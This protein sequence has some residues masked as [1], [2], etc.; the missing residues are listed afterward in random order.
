MQQ[1]IHSIRV[2][3][4]DDVVNSNKWLLTDKSNTCEWN[5]AVNKF[6]SYE[7][8]TIVVMEK[9]DR[10]ITEEFCDQS[11]RRFWQRIADLERH[12]SM[13]FHRFLS[14]SQSIQIYINELRIE[15][16]DPYLSHSSL[17]KSGRSNCQNII[18]I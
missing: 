8:G 3:D 9:L 2:W 7:Q 12:L 15:P 18:T 11:T 4:I 10:L 13:V 16:W 6:S 14:G 17:R 1:K 5:S